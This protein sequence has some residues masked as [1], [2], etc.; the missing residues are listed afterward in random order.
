M[1]GYVQLQKWVLPDLLKL[2]VSG[3]YDKNENFD[4]RFTPRA[5]ALIKVAKDNSFRLSYQQ[6]YRF[7]STQDQ[8]INLRTPA[9]ILIGGLPD[10]IDY[11]NF[12]GSPA[13]TAESIVLY[14]NSVNSGAPNPGLLE[15]AAFPELKPEIANSYEVGF[16]GLIR[17]DLLVDAY[18]YYSEYKDFIGRVAVGRGQSGNPSPAVAFVELASPFTTSNYSFVYNSSSTVKAIGWGI[19]ANYRIGKGFEIGVNVS[20]DKLR[21]V[22]PGLVTF[23]NTPKLRYNITLG[24]ERIGRT[25]WGFNLLYRWQDEVLW[26][27]TFGTGEVPSF[28]TLDGQVSYRVPGIKSLIKVGA[29]NLLNKY[30]TS[31]FGN[32]SVGGLYYVAFAFNV[33]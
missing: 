21:D 27:G 9:S 5:T 32:P 7:P 22:E 31:A 3:R 30:Y 8:W 17:R 6:A 13:Y 19:S 16:R 14:R 15:A 11:Y 29:T 1:G 10:F 28:G 4:G 24:N 12:D 33:Y 23:F 26:E 20:G 25:N 18:V 2:T